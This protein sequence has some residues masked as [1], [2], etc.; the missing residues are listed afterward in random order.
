MILYDFMCWKV[1]IN[2]GHLEVH[3]STFFE[4]VSAAATFNSSGI[5]QN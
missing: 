4:A 3:M 5:V 2:V 1:V